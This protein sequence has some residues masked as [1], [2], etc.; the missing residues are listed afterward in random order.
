[1][2]VLV[3]GG[4]GFVMA[5][6]LRHWLEADERNTAVCIDAASL[7]AAATR[8]FEPVRGRMLFI[9]GSISAPE[10][11]QGLPSDIAQVV[12]GAA[13]TP[14][15]YVGADGMKR[16]PERENPLRVIETNIVGT[17][18]ALEWARNL[19]DLRRFVYVS[20][21]SVYLGEV[22]AQ[23]MSP[24]ALPE[25]GY[26]GPHGLYDVTKYSGELITRRLSELY[27]YSAVSIRLSNVFG[28]MDRQ[29]PFRN[30][31]NPANIIA[32]AAVEGRAV[33]AVNPDVPGDYIYAPDVARAI[34][35]LL[36]AASGALAHGVYNIAYGAPALLCELL[37]YARQAAPGLT[38]EIASDCA[39]DIKLDMDRS[40]GRWGAYDISRATQDFGWRPR[41]LGEAMTDYIAWLREQRRQ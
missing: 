38:L 22:P 28:P 2:K 19:P 8:F 17:A 3:T 7:D 34:R 40:T 41:P 32:R 25:E 6:F 23:R 13:M 11:W 16:E 33:K 5:N 20:T 39:A 10:T 4:G 21:G 24:F 18:R 1:M 26:I 12:H 27:G 35:L 36:E 37:A 9:Q 14:H 31:R 15:A 29:T 30:V